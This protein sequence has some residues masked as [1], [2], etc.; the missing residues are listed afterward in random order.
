MSRF[1]DQL[2]IVNE[3]S[4]ANFLL[5]TDEND[6]KALVRIPADGLGGGGSEFTLIEDSNLNNF[7]I[8][9]VSG[10]WIYNGTTLANLDLF[11]NDGQ[12]IG[13]INATSNYV[14]LYGVNGWIINGTTYSLIPDAAIR[15]AKGH[16]L[17]CYID[18]KL[19]IL[20][21]SP[22]VMGSGPGRPQ[23]DPYIAEIITY[24]KFEGAN[25]SKAIIDSALTP[26]TY[27][28]L[29]TAEISTNRAKFGSS[30]L[31]AA[32]SIYSYI[33]SDNLNIS[34][35]NTFTIEG[36]YMFEPWNDQRSVFALKPSGLSELICAANYGVL[37][38][39]GAGQSTLFTNFNPPSN[40]WTHVA[41]SC[42]AGVV[43]IFVDGIQRGD[44]GSFA[45]NSWNLNY[46]KLG[47]DSAGKTASYID[48]FRITKGISR[49][50][51]NFDP[52]TDSFW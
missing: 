31:Y 11:L 3:P 40:V 19:I 33:I 14:F 48:S 50:N 16:I 46:I 1:A 6:P 23:V 10:N 42:N 38:L 28:V 37:A 45:N 20:S 30:S 24:L 41:V 25:G 7:S 43:K 27:Q 13:I 15:L 18:G 9:I 21:S 29:N 8:D 39:W 17:A 4:A 36:W 51:Q 26:L 5:G 35:S 34:F 12:S 47:S 49:Y 44:N 52:Q 32:Q 2:P 22:L